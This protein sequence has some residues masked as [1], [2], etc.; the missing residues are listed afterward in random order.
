MLSSRLATISNHKVWRG[1][2]AIPLSATEYRL[3][4]YLVNNAGKVITRQDIADNCWDEPF[5]TFTNIID[6][7]INYLRKKVDDGQFATKLIH[8]VRGKGYTLDSKQS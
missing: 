6:F 2:T 4:N 8:T 1:K 5:E 3:L 7:Y